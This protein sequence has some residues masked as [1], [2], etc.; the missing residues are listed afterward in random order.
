[1]GHPHPAFAPQIQILE[2]ESNPG[3]P[4]PAKLTSIEVAQRVHPVLDLADVTGGVTSDVG[5]D[6][7]PVV[8]GRDHVVL[9]RRDRRGRGRVV[10]AFVLVLKGRGPAV[11]RCVM[12]GVDRGGRGGG[13]RAG[14]ERGN[15]FGFTF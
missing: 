14:T 8:D 7:D 10:V 6:H 3:S 4:L 13:Q 1:M 11:L 9:R 12:V 5:V 2:L 15:V